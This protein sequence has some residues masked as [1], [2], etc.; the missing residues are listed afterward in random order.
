[1][2]SVTVERAGLV[3]GIL[4]LVSG[5]VTLW[6]DHQRRRR[7][8]TLDAYLQAGEY[9]GKL[10]DAVHGEK[11]PRPVSEE[12]LTLEEAY[13]LSVHPSL[14]A[15]HLREY[16]NFWEQIAVGV[17]M[18]VFD[19]RTL[20]KLSRTHLRKL[21]E[22]YAAYVYFVRRRTGENYYPSLE[23]LAKKY[24]ADV[25]PAEY[26]RFWAAQAEAPVS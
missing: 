18:R 24:G 4:T 14:R 9:R 21:Y 19:R 1:M 5:V 15:D 7:Q 20:K 22:R 17:R 6:L 11:V 12:P 13:A 10:E 25:R 16:L 3:V 8:A 26:E 23:R 2:D